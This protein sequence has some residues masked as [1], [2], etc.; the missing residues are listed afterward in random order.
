MIHYR[1]DCTIFFL[2][3]QV[4]VHVDNQQKNLTEIKVLAPNENLF[5][6]NFISHFIIKKL[7]PDV[8][9]SKTP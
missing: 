8:S 6:L 2:V 4:V 3:S 5:M 1:Y 9:A 7:L